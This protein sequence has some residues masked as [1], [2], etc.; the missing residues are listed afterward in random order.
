MSSSLLLVAGGGGAS[1]LLFLSLLVGGTGAL[2]FAY[3]APLPLLL[4]GLGPGF[5]AAALGGVTAAAAVSVVGNVIAGI[6]FALANMAPALLVARQALLA[7]RRSDGEVEWYPPGNLVLVLA[8]Y[9]VVLIL[10]AAILAGGEDGGLEGLVRGAVMGTLDSI[11]GFAED[12]E[13]DAVRALGDMLV[14]V[15]PALVV[16]SWLL[17]TVA[18]AALAQGLLMRF[19]RNRRPPMRMSEVALPGWTPAALAAT[20]VLA[21]LADGTLGYVATNAALVLLVPFFFAG[22]GVVHAFAETR[23]GRAMLLVLFYLFAFVLFQWVVPLVVGLGLIEHW[24]GLRARLPRP[25]PSSEDV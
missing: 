1:A 6:A 25:R 18:N 7:R 8:G 4:L 14:P 22:L 21:V 16:V 20:G 24:A 12:G 3:L 15:F 23:P 10:G 11:A 13:P 5:V 19:G 17:M 2:I 9:G